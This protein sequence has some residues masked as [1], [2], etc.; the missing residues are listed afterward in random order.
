MLQIS[1]SIVTGEVE[2]S[3]EFFPNSIDFKG[4]SMFG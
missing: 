3:Y 2:I 4:E 1:G